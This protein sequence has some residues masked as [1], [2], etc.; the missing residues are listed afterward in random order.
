MVDHNIFYKYSQTET[1]FSAYDANSIMHYPIDSALTTDGSSVPMNND[2]SA[3]DKQYAAIFYPFPATP[4]VATGTLKTGDDCDEIDFKI[5]FDAVERDKVELVLQPG[6]NRNGKVIDWWKQVSLPLIGYKPLLI[7]ME[8]GKS[9]KGS[10]G[11]VH[12]DDA[13]GI[14][15]S[16][17]KLLGVHTEL[18][19]KWNIL[20]AV[21]G[22][23]R[24]TLTWRNDSCL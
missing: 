21:R 2:L 10:V 17:A 1:N 14:G 11:R 23:C 4:P 7:Q 9:S 13:K 18:T 16:K 12:L 22:G 5:E 19:Y 15:F 24:I 3:T 6:I 8:G 20:K